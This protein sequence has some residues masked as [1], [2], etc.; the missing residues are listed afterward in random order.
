MSWKRFFPIFDWISEYNKSVFRSDLTAG[1][2]VCIMLIPQGM[3][4]ALL[5]GMPPIYGLYGGLVPLLIYGL[6]G[7]SRQLSIGP[8]AVSSLLVLAGISQVAEPESGQYIELAIL[9]GL[10]IGIAQLLLSALRLGFLVTFLSHPVIMGFTSA[11]AIIIAVS[12]FKYLFG[13]PIPRF[14]QTYETAIYA[15]EHLNQIH[16]LSF[17]FCTSGIIV[18]LAIKKWARF[19]P[20]ALVVTIL[21]I[22]ITYLLKLDQQGLAIVGKVPE[23][24][25]SF[26]VPNL[27]WTNIQLV[28]PTVGTVTIM[29]VVE[30]ISIAK[31][32]E[33]KNKDGRIRPN[34][35]LFAIGFSKFAGAF[36]QALPTSAS[37][38]RSA[39][40]NEAGARTGIASIIAAAATG[41]TLV[42]FTPLFYYLPKAILASIVL[43]AV[44]GLFELEGAK[45][46]WKTHR[47][48]FFMMLITFLATLG[49]GIEEGV[50]T[51]VILSLL[52]VI[53]QASRPH[54][55]IL[56]KLPKT[57]HFR[58]VDRFPEAQQ[59]DGVIIIRFDAPLF[60]LN[61][62][63]FKNTVFDTLEK[64]N[65]RCYLFILD[66]SSIL[67]IDSSGLHAIEEVYNHFKERNIQFFIAGVLGPVRDAF[68]RYE[69][70][71]KVGLTNHFMYVSDALEYYRQEKSG[72]QALWTNNAIQHNLKNKN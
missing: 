37:F 61:A 33:A 20:A 12:Q 35:E 66:A 43:M 42:F 59:E 25:P 30:S 21:G 32:L 36:F 54:S 50:L 38:T 6:L 39:V 72:Q 5:A 46:L 41:L 26:S 28:L 55:A 48:D 47:K 22:L 49:M 64:Y 10:M 8:V 67:D 15:F 2:T 16:W 3:A 11:A 29:G 70:I 63:Q 58:N 13:F 52:L 24:L 57:N 19:I 69:L 17:A 45:E 27:S 53:Y 1:L 23:G 9:A 65:D 68:K 18:M 31:A 34:Q 14:E 40:N 51:G 71:E 4:Y 60:F 62:E 7:T 44:K 56:G